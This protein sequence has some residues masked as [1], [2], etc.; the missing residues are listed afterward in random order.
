[1]LRPDVA[2]AVLAL[3]LPEPDLDLTLDPDDV[4]LTPHAVQ[5]YR[6]R[7]EGVPR[8]LAVRRLRDLIATAHWRARPRAWTEIVLHPEV[9]YGYGPS[10]PDVCL[11]VR[12]QAL[13]TVMSRRLLMRAMGCTKVGSCG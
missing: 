10:R 4:V 7:V 8:R 9:I 13:V 2:T 6:E 1:M 11:L 12:R 5:R 3:A